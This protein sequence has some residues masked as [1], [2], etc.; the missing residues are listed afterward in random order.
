[1][2]WKVREEKD[3]H[4]GSLYGP[5]FQSSDKGCLLMYAALP[6]YTSR[7]DAELFK[8]TAMIER[9]LNKDTLGFSISKSIT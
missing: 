4:A 6:N 5:V 8:K 3:K 9:I 7:E 1:M 2:G